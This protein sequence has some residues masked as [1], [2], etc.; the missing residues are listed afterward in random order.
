MI[1]KI[2]LNK[3][4][5]KLII[6]LFLLYIF[7]IIS[8]KLKVKMIKIIQIKIIIKYKFLIKLI[9]SQ[10]KHNKTFI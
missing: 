6:F 4:I 9:I 5:N 7:R 2:K 1:L 3:K 8:K 10:I